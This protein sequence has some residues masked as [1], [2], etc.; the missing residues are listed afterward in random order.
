M[1]FSTFLPLAAC[2]VWPASAGAASAQVRF[3]DD[4]ENG[5][6]KWEIYGERGVLLHDTGDPAY[7]RVMVLHPYGDVLALIKESENWGAVRIEADV[8]FSD[9]ERSQ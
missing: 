8:L 4:F 1:R 6:G 5:L 7:G 2:L 3:T 9:D